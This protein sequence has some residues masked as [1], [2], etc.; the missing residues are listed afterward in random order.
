MLDSARFAK[1]PP[2]DLPSIA[3]EHYRMDITGS[4]AGRPVRMPFG[5]AAG[6]LSMTV[7]EA[8]TDA[9]AG[10][11]FVVLKTVIAQDSAGGSTMA[12]W[13][14]H[15]SVM[16]V[17]PLLSRGGRTGWTVTWKGRGWDR[18]FDDY[19]SLYRDALAVGDAAA[20]PVAASV[21]YHLPVSGVGFQVS[22][23]EYTTKKL[24]EIGGAGTIIEKDFSPTLAA[25]ERSAEKE[26]ILRWLREVPALIKRHAPV[27]LGLKLMNALFDDDVQVEMLEAVSENPDVDY[28]TLFNRLWDPEKQAAYGGWDLSDRNLRVLDRYAARCGPLRLRGPATPGFS[29]TGNICSGKMMI[30]YA[31]RGATSGQ[32]HTFFQLPKSEYL[33]AAGSTTQRALHALVFH[34]EEGLIAW[35]AHLAETGVL[36]PRDGLLHFLDTANGP[37]RHPA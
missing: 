10:L 26:T 21:K 15:E 27:T 2:A 34:P 28:V 9:E 19:L 5:T 30:E 33:A 6:Q 29:A 8:R 17:G 12:D 13:A 36:Q 3:R 4:Y 1:Q 25:D 7:K 37:A 11:G 18:S 32:I 16:D 23:Y 20:M 14:V 35:M 31:L 22:E 24:A